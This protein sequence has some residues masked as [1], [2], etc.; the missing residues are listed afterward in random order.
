MAAGPDLIADE[1]GHAKTIIIFLGSTNLIEGS[2]VP[3]CNRGTP[4]CP[5]VPKNRRI[6]S[7]FL[8]QRSLK[9]QSET[10][11]CVRKG[12]SILFTKRELNFVH[13]M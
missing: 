8:T 3:K 1:V 6:Q 12:K 4:F 2:R 9:D 11:I 5:I 10:M 13:K 7:N